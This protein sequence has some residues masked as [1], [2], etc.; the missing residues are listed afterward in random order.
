MLHAAR[1]ADGSAVI[2]C[3]CLQRRLGRQAYCLAWENVCSVSGRVEKCYV[4][5]AFNC[6][7]LMVYIWSGVENCHYG[8]CL[9]APQTQSLSISQSTAYAEGQCSQVLRLN[10]LRLINLI[11]N[12]GCGLLSLRPKPPSGSIS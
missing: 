5:P 10:S 11:Q 9:D 12:Y 1:A 4:W 8:M 7:Q 3:L 2:D 6:F